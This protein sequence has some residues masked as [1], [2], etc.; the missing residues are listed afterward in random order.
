MK[1]YLAIARAWLEKHSSPSPEDLAELLRVEAGV[2]TLVSPE[3]TPAVPFSPPDVSVS[4]STP[5]AAAIVT[6]PDEPTPPELTRRQ[7]DALTTKTLKVLG[8]ERSHTSLRA[9]PHKLR[10][11]A[12]HARVDVK[13]LKEFLAGRQVRTQFSHTIKRSL[14]ELGFPT[15]PG[16]PS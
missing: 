13:V 1:D 3:S 5:S 12:Q 15:E 14:R 10:A 2:S 11:V 6:A 8:K 16:L 4:S 9:A 7:E